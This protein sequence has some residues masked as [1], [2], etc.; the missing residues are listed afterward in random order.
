MTFAETNHHPVVTDGEFR[1][2]LRV[3]RDFAFKGQLAENAAWVRAWYAAH[4]RPWLWARAAATGGVE[5]E[6]TTLEDAALTSG[7]LARRFREAHGAVVVAASAGLEAEAEAAR[8][9]AEDEPDRYYFMEAYA[10]AVVEALIAKARVRLCAWAASQ[11]AVVRSHYSPGYEGWSV[12]EH[13]QVLSLL[14]RSGPMPGPLGVMASGMLQ[15]KKSQLAVFALAPATGAAGEPADLVPCRY[16]AWAQCEC[17]R[18][19]C[20]LA[21]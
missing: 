21:P 1:R 19:P 12:G 2:L 13:A 6:V 18:E 9:W 4:G 20:V 17:R 14:T 3:P 5:G 8:C 15:P 7:E 11:G 16:C 10:T